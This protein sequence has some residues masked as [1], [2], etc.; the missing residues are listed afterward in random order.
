MPL[1]VALDGPAGSGKSSVSRAVATKLGIGY[2]D[3]GAMYR[4]AT[5]WVLHR[6]I[7]PADAAG[8]A[9]AVRDFELRIGTD[10]ERP[11]VAVAGQDVTA[12]IREPDVTAN[13]SAVSA[14]PAVRAEMVA[15]QRVAA[16]ECAHRTG[17]VIVEGRDIGTTVLPDAPLKIFLTADAEARAARRHLEDRGAG[18]ASGELDRT[19]AALRA[20]DAAEAGRT[21]SP[22]QRADDAV[23]V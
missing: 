23:A 6:G 16:A 3:T 15:R 9:D 2:L 11:Q 19:L 8:V 17:G 7:D 21:E 14:V 10:P 18:R 13:V 20:R 4:A 12:A 5:W 22:M 1:V